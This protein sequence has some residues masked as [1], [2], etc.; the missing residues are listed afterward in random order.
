MVL[1]NCRECGKLITSGSGN[2]CAD[3]TT[4]RHREMAK[5]RDCIR[6]NS[7]VNLLELST[8]TGISTKRLL[9]FIHEGLVEVG[10]EPLFD[11]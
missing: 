8:H 5:I 7:G 6:K 4:V 1:A 10:E 11:E 9:Q 2:L 3:C